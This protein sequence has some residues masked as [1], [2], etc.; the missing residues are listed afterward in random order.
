MIL[1]YNFHENI[2]IYNCSVKSDILYI[3][4]SSVKDY[5][6]DPSGTYSKYNDEILILFDLKRRIRVK[7]EDFTDCLKT[8]DNMDNKVLIDSTLYDYNDERIV[9]I[10]LN[11]L[12]EKNL[13]NGCIKKAYSEIHKIVDDLDIPLYQ[14]HVEIIG[15]LS[16][17]IINAHVTDILKINDDVY[18]ILQNVDENIYNINNLETGEL[19]YRIMFGSNTNK[20]ENGIIYIKYSYYLSYIHYYDKY[21][22]IRNID[23]NKYIKIDMISSELYSDDM[24]LKVGINVIHYFGSKSSSDFISD[25]ESDEFEDVSDT[26][27]DSDNDSENEDSDDIIPHID[28]NTNSDE[29]ICESDVYMH[30]IKGDYKKF[31]YIHNGKRYI[32]DVEDDVLINFEPNIYDEFSID[33]NVL[34][35]NTSCHIGHVVYENESYYIVLNND[36]LE[37]Y[38]NENSHH[39]HVNKIE[40]LLR[41]NSEQMVIG[42]EDDNVSMSVDLLKYKS[43]FV[44]DLFGIM[45]VDLDKGFVSKYLKNISLYK[46]YV[47]NFKNFINGKYDEDKLYDLFV[48]SD[49][50]QDIN[51]ECIAERILHHVSGYNVG[52]DEAYKYLKVIYFSTCYKYSLPLLYIIDKKYD[53]RHL[54]DKL[55]N[56]ENDKLYRFL[57]SDLLYSYAKLLNN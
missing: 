42:T 24:D 22:L 29:N 41:L 12:I 45:N 5:D 31:F 10:D 57:T 55:I 32:Y 4:G 8:Y 14:S 37:I 17:K 46:E 39:E 35:N 54:I 50:M 6:L 26:D 30:S 16:V 47:E 3:H 38:I 7:N 18:Y 23:N 36:E 43:I 20:I 49:Y 56:D 1:I 2:K 53:R 34:I 21:L 44:K 27:S 19:F 13:P 52:I 15:G 40:D 48:I 51:L 33:E 25:D 28:I 9:A 11:E